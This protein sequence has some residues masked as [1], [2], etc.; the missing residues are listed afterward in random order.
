M[1]RGRTWHNTKTLIFCFLFPSH[2]QTQDSRRAPVVR[3]KV[4]EGSSW[5]RTP[6][7]KPGCILRTKSFWSEFCVSHI[8]L[9]NS[10]DEDCYKISSFSSSPQTELQLYSLACHGTSASPVLLRSH[11]C[12]RTE[13]STMPTVLSYFPAHSLGV[14]GCQHLC[15]KTQKRDLGKRLGHQDYTTKN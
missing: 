7:E 1:T 6:T 13:L 14:L 12:P 9:L 8:C 10:Y 3:Q 4:K 2:T 11:N 5:Q 15:L